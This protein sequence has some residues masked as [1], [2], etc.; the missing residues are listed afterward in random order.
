M[1]K[2]R[3]DSRYMKLLKHLCN[4]TTLQVNKIPVKRGVRQ[5]DTISLKL[6]TLILDNVFKM[7]DQVYKGDQDQRK[8]FEPPPIHE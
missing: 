4:N 3:I 2:A 7:L 8:T 1:D 5:W 6:F